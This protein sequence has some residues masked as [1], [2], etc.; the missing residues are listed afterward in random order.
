[1]NLGVSIEHRVAAG[2]AYFDRVGAADAD[3]TLSGHDLKLAITAVLGVRLNKYEV[4]TLISTTTRRGSRGAATTG[5]GV[6]GGGA[7]DLLR[8]R[9]R[10]ASRDNVMTRDEFVG[11]MSRRLAAEDERSSLR[12]LFQVFDPRDRGYISFDDLERV[13]GSAAPL[14]PHAAAADAFCEA[15]ATSSIAAPGGVGGGS[16]SRISYEQFVRLMTYGSRD[17]ERGVA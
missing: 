9:P 1:M 14:L 3:A 6:V 4:A 17:G 11:A 16:R 8:R 12:A 13:L 2:L 15:A 10:L 7:D 5:P